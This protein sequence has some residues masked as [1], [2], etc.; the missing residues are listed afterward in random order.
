[1]SGSSQPIGKKPQHSFFTRASTKTADLARAA[2]SQISSIPISSIKFTPPKNLSEQLREKAV[3]IAMQAK[4]VSIFTVKTLLTSGTITQMQPAMTGIGGL[5]IG[6]NLPAGVI[7]TY[8]LVKNW[9]S[10]SK[11]GRAVKSAQIL[12]NALLTAAGGSLLFS[13]VKSLAALIGPSH[14]AVAA[15]TAFILGPIGMAILSVLSLGM[16][17]VS[18]K[19]AT[20]FENKR[21][22]AAAKRDRTNDPLEKALFSREVERF[23]AQRDFAVANAMK[24]FLVGVG[25]GI[26]AAV[27]SGIVAGALATPFGW[28]A[29]GLVGAG[30]VI[31]IGIIVVQR[32]KAA[33]K[34]QAENDGLVQEIITQLQQMGLQGRSI[35]DAVKNLNANMTEEVLT[36]SGWPG[37]P[38][39]LELIEREATK[40][41]IT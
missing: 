11:M 35:E 33:E 26:G 13:K 41:G 32:S 16:G 36:S 28:A 1:M 38:T 31:G 4:A 17:A 27:M 39:L 40:Q 14:A 19:N 37:N 30:L 7:N 20:A 24:Y 2:K 3:P 34:E 22:E 8:S 21:K 9:K 5:F 6:I 10:T 15:K 18:V 23:A 29:V 25:I 12:S